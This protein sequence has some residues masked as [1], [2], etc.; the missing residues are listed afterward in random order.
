MSPP[1]LREPPP[2]EGDGSPLVPLALGALALARRMDALLDRRV[3][4]EAD[5]S[6][7]DPLLYAALG[8][9]ALRR[10]LERLLRHACPEPAEAGA[11]RDAAPPLPRE[12]L[13]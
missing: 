13:R 6:P 4:A 1:K 9:V 7:D 12:L 8:A 11:T 3:E 10:Q 5:P 2:E